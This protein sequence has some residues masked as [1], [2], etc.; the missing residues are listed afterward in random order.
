MLVGEAVAVTDP[1][2]VAVD[3]TENVV[4]EGAGVPSTENV[5]PSSP[6]FPVPAMVYKEPTTGVNGG[7]NSVNV[8]V[9]MSM[10]GLEYAVIDRTDPPLLLV[11]VNEGGAPGPH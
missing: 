3:S 9:M 6:A 2:P 5:F 4:S 8:N 1:E 7:V 11:T 10:L